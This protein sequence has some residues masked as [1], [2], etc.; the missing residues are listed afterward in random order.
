M[1]NAV[2]EGPADTTIVETPSAPITK[3]D[4]PKLILVA[5]YSIVSQ[6]ADF[7]SDSGREIF[8]STT[9]IMG[10]AMHIAQKL[11]FVSDEEQYIYK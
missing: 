5:E 10:F 7:Y 4:E 3:N 2:G 11:I 1:T 6:G 8:S 9:R